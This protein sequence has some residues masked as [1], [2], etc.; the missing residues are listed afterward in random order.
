MHA[1]LEY[2]YADD[3]LESR[4]QYRGLHLKAAWEAVERGEL[5]LG[6]AVGEGPFTGLL[7]FTGDSA[8]DAAKAFV[9]ADPYVAGG[10]VTSWTARP[11]TTV[12]GH[13]AATPVQP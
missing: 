2:T 9:A 5:L 3:Y 7:I 8:L 4:E 1:V 10:V 12:V 6:G 11:W 13:E